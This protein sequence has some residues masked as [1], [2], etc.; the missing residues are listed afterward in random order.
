MAGVH[1]TPKISNTACLYSITRLIEHFNDANTS[2]FRQLLIKE[3]NYYNEAE[4]LCKILPFLSKSMTNE[5]LTILKNETIKLSEQQP[6]KYDK[7]IS[8]YKQVQ[9]Q[10]KG[11]LSNLHSD[12]IDYFGTFLSKKQ[13]IE[14]GYLNRQLYI[15]TQKQSY[16]LKR[17]NINDQPLVLDNIRVEKFFHNQTNLFSYTLPTQLHLAISESTKQQQLQHS[18]WYK[19]NAFS[20]LNSFTCQFHVNQCLGA[21]PVQQFFC[22]NRNRNLN[23]F[24]QKHMGGHVQGR[25]QDIK[26]FECIAGVWNK[27][28]IITF[29]NNFDNYFSNVCKNE[30]NNIRNIEQLTVQNTCDMIHD[31]MSQLL[32]TLG[33]ISKKIKMEKCAVDVKDINQLKRIFHTN[34]KAL[35]YD[36]YSMIKYS[37]NGNDIDYKIPHFDVSDLEISIIVQDARYYSYTPSSFSAII[38]QLRSQ[39]KVQCLKISLFRKEFKNRLQPIFVDVFNITSATHHNHDTD[40]DNIYT[41]MNMKEKIVIIVHDQENL[42]T[43]AEILSLFN[44][45]RSQILNSAI[46]NIQKITIQFCLNKVYPYQINA[47]KWNGLMWEQKSDTEYPVDSN[48]IE[49]KNCDLQAKELGVM[50]QNIIKWFQ[51]IEKKYGNNELKQSFY[52]DLTLNK[53]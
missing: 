28:E 39:S 42:F 38:K 51:N 26:K 2:K 47:G 16:L 48:K 31:D 21:I 18:Q 14:I 29:C 40:N 25:S 35:E 9:K 13:S 8:V 30:V 43:F 44:E 34:L 22:Q 5:S 4:L 12:I 27:K 53:I 15:E 7:T 32:L 45:N 11:R 36:V 23:H 24:T 3:L 41:H 52:L 10:N 33:Q 6:S 46:N 50:Y 19:K 20:V 49:Y 1:A 17:L 37:H